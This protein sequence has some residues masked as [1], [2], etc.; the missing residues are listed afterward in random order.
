MKKVL[1]LGAGHVARPL[2]DYL[3]KFENFELT[4]AD[5]SM[6]NAAALCQN[7]A[8][9]KAIVLDIEND[10]T[11]SDHIF[12]SDVVIS[13]LPYSYHPIVARLC[14]S[15]KTALVTASYMTPEIEQLDAEAK[16]AGIII[17]KEMGLDPGI[18]H[19]SAMQI[20]DDVQNRGGKMISFKSYCGGLPAPEADTNPWHYKFSWSPLGVLL[21]ARND[22]R[23]LFEKKE[24]NIANDDMLHFTESLM[25]ENLALEAY[26][27]RDSI[28]YIRRY[29]LPE[30]STM[31]RYTLRYPGWVRSMQALKKI[32]FLDDKIVPETGQ[33]S[34]LHTL[35][36]LS[37][38]KDL[39]MYY[40]YAAGELW[41]QDV[42]TR[43]E[44]LGLFDTHF[45]NPGGRAVSPLDMLTRRMA[46]RMGYMKNERDMIL[47]HHEFIY[48]LDRRMIRRTSTLSDYGQPG[49][50]S[51]MARTVGLPVAIGAR[52]ILENKIDRS[53]VLL[54]LTAD[55]Y[56]P[57]LIELKRL[58]IR[59]QE[60]ENTLNSMQV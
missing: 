56:A 44:W 58:G 51:A 16:A 4:V 28:G 38:Y 19:M 27:N 14:I 15:G 21:A 23:Y 42:A 30:I 53:G 8:R 5:I 20:I 55:I 17:L 49:G 45:D 59:F 3:H 24:V 60:R 29:H 11:I 41:N 40:D 37:V 54:P 32:G 43:F 9:S 52:L 13:L 1:V 26:P 12:Q 2:V 57:V 7:H 10:P 36:Q 50:D 48:E 22:A 31:I 25:L 46:R 47:L 35:F 18:D 33:K 39:K 34:D 6:Q